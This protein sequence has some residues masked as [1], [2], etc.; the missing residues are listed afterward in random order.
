VILSTHILS[1]VEM[2]C[3]RVLILHRGRLAK[4]ARMD[5]LRSGEGPRLEEAFLRILG[6]VPE[7]GSP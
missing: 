1:E 6:E 7:G 5:D 2:V 3:G 4:D